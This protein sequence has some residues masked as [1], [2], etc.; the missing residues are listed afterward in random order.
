MLYAC[1]WRL[2]TRCSKTI[3]Y[4]LFKICIVCRCQYFADQMVCIVLNAISLIHS[5]LI[6]TLH[7]YIFVIWLCK[8]LQANIDSKALICACS[9]LNWE[10][11]SPFF[12]RKYGKS[13]SYL[14][15]DGHVCSRSSSNLY[16]TPLSCSESDFSCFSS[17]SV[18]SVSFSNPFSH[19]IFIL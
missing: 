1:G 7:S 12:V 14:V 16:S 6:M 19:H 8:H 17:C 15:Q 4:S 9:L 2:R 13:I 10:L 11:W 5:A 18:L 3:L